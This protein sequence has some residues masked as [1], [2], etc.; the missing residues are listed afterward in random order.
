MINKYYVDF[1]SI[2]VRIVFNTCADAA[3]V[4]RDLILVHGFGESISVQRMPLT[5]N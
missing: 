4:K 3:E 2:P 1:H 5:P